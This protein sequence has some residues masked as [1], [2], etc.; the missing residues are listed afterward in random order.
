[1]MGDLLDRVQRDETIPGEHRLL[2]AVIALACRD[3]RRGNGHTASAWRFLNGEGF[4][5]YAHVL[6]YSPEDLMAWLVAAGEL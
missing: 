2:F 3:A 4:A 1:M 5:T 6:G